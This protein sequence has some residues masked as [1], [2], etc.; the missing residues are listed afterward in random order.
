MVTSHGGAGFWLLPK[1]RKKKEKLYIYIYIYL[2]RIR[3]KEQN[4]RELEVKKK[5]EFGLMLTPC[6]TY[7]PLGERVAVYFLPLERGFLVHKVFSVLVL[8]C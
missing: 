2:Y 8:L 5:T 6:Q 3:S 7:F 1:R 4:K